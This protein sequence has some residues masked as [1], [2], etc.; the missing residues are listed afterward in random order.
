[1][2]LQR[3][4]SLPVRTQLAGMSALILVLVLLILSILLNT[5]LGA[6]LIDKEASRLRQLSGSVTTGINQRI[7]FMPMPNRGPNAPPAANRGLQQRD[8]DEVFLAEQ[9]QRINTRDTTAI[10]LGLD[11]TSLANSRSADDPTP[12]AHL[13]KSILDQA[14][15]S[16][17]EVVTIVSGEHERLLVLLKPLLRNGAPVAFLQLS[18]SLETIDEILATLRLWSMLGMLGA[19]LLG[20]M[21]T[22]LITRALLAPLEQVVETSEK[23]A[24]GDLSL[25]LNLPVDSR[26]EIGK[27]GTAFD[28]M[29]DRLED[30]FHAQR[31]FVADASHEL[32]T[33]LTALGGLSEML[34]MGI[35]AGDERKTQH[36]LRSMN[37]EIDRMSRL[38]GDLLTLSRLDVGTPM[39]LQPVDLQLLAE[40]VLQESEALAGEKQV[41]LYA[42]GPVYVEGDPD[43]LKQVMLNLITNAIQHTPPSNAGKITISVKRNTETAI[44]S[45]ADNGDGISADDI[46]HIFERFYRADKSRARRSGGLGLGLAIAHAIVHAHHGSI[47][48]VSSP[49]QGSIFTVCLPLYVDKMGPS[50]QPN[51]Y[52]SSGSIAGLIKS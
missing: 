44:L 25:R 37:S 46:S 49:G 3:L 27:L 45:V 34:L 26:N 6:F 31:Q 38:V 40:E 8:A 33:P 35:D 24:E 11:G 15:T 48:V 5:L 19:A 14:Y 23:I 42:D 18:T 1:M 36:I 10:V 50:P 12:I 13:D 51:A 41:S 32:R 21:L 29:V 9:V 28:R 20:S 22:I 52:R 30:A 43:R 4:R 39:T 2:I 16:R 17:Q 47:E 7:G